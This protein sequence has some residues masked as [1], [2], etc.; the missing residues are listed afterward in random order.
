M[1]C[2]CIGIY[3]NSNIKSDVQLIDHTYYILLSAIFIIDCF[4]QTQGIKCKGRLMRTFQGVKEMIWNHLVC[5]YTY[6]RLTLVGKGVLSHLQTT[7]SM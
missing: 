5:V 3:K 6:E 7:T 1:S 2:E 4:V